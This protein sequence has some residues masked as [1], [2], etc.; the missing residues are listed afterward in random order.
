METW[1]IKFQGSDTKRSFNIWLQQAYFMIEINI[2]DKLYLIFNIHPLLLSRRVRLRFRCLACFQRSWLFSQWWLFS[3]V[4]RDHSQWIFILFLSR[5]FSLPA[6]IPLHPSSY[7]FGSICIGFMV[8][9]H[10]DPLR[11]SIQIY[12]P[13]CNQHFWWDFS[14]IF[15]C[16]G[17]FCS[18]FD[19]GRGSLWGSKHIILSCK[20]SWSIFLSIQWW[21]CNNSWFWFCLAPRSFP[22]PSFFSRLSS[23]ASS[24]T[25]SILCSGNH[26]HRIPTTNIH[27]L[28]WELFEELPS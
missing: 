6:V 2:D 20:D 5:L 18:Q 25:F 10:R 4:I 15:H 8:L 9:H 12:S 14:C 13:P 11:T 28:E 17:E 16:P 1:E 7:H 23:S 19:L 24:C 26:H 3:W 27:K 22:S 21:S